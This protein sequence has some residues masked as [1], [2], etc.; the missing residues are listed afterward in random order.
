MIAAKYQHRQNVSALYNST[1]IA[2]VT[3]QF[4]ILQTEHEGLTQY[5][6]MLYIKVI[7]RGWF[8]SFYLSTVNDLN[9]FFTTD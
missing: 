4:D 5:Y 3:S 2:T 6:V 1:V 9:V 7:F 8:C